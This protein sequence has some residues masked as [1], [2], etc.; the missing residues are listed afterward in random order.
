[1][2]VSVVFGSGNLRTEAVS[3]G[4]IQFISYAVNTCSG[5]I[6]NLNVLSL[7]VCLPIGIGP[8][9]SYSIITK[10]GYI[11]TAQGY[12]DAACTITAGASQSLPLNT[13]T[14]QGG[15]YVTLYAYPPNTIPP[16]PFTTVSGQ[17]T[18]NYA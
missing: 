8:G 15:S 5:T 17:V 3:S 6:T 4:T 10:S 2:T 1:M 7:D 12:S 11:V 13:C 14:S 18:A 9:S 16:A